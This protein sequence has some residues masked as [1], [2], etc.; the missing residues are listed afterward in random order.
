MSDYRRWRVEG[1]T[2]FFTLNTHNR[3]PFLTTKSARR[4][5]HRAFHI[6]RHKWPFRLIAAVVLPDHL[7]AV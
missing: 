6:V 5:L 7:H 4:C 1:G 2:Y 3:E